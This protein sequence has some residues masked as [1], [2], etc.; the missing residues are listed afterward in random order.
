MKIRTASGKRTNLAALILMLS[1][2]MAAAATA[3]KELTF[4]EVM[5]FRQ[6]RDPVVSAD[7]AWLAYAAQPDRGDGEGFVQSVK[8]ERSF[9]IERGANPV[10]SRDSRWAA[11]TIT[12]RALELEKAGKEKPRQGMALVRLS[13]GEVVLAENVEQFAFS[14]DSA[15]LAYRLFPEEPKE[16]KNEAD[17]G[18]EKKKERG[19][20]LVLRKLASGVEVRIPQTLSFAFDESG[21]FLAY[22]RL[23]PKEADNGLLLRLLKKEGCPEKAAARAPGIRYSS[24]T[25]SEKDGR[26]AFVAAPLDDKDRSGPGSLRLW[27]AETER[28]RTAA[29][30]RS[31]PAGWGI[32]EKNRLTWTKDGRRLFFGIKPMEHFDRERETQDGKPSEEKDLYD[33]EKILAETEVDVWHWNDPLINSHQKKLWARLKDRLFTAVFH[34]DSGKTVPL[35]VTDMPVVEPVE[36]PV[37]ALGMS[38][39][40]YLKERTWDGEYFDLFVVSLADGTRKPVAARI[41]SAYRSRPSLSPEGRYAVYYDRGHWFLYDGRLDKTVNLTSGLGVPFGDEEHDTPDESPGYGLAGWLENDAAVLINDKFDVWI[42]P[43]SGG[44]PSMLTGGAGRREGRIFRV[45]KTDPEFRFFSKK[46]TLLLSMFHER[47]KHHGFYSARI[48]R[49][50][51]TRLLE[52]KKKFVFRAKAENADVVLYT[53]ESFEE[54]PDLWA[55]DMT[56]AAARRLT[57]INPRIREFAWGSAEL[58]EWLSLDGRPLQ[59]V[60]IKPAGYEKGKRYPVLVYFYEI[61][62]HRLYEYNQTV[63]NHRPCFPVYAGRGY[64]VFLPDVRYETGRPGLSALKCVAPGVQK[65]ID[66][67]VADPKALGLHGHSWG[68]YETAFIVTQTDMFACAIA[69]AAVGNMTSAYGGIRWESGMAR[70]FQYEKSQSRIGGSLWESP[71]LYWA[72]SP[73]FLADRIRTPL[74]LMHGDEDGAVPWYQSIELYLAMRRLGKDCIFLQYRGEPHHPRKYANK[75]DY[76][77]RMMEYLDHHLRGLPAPDWMTKG[78]AYDGR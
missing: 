72:N 51:A 16:G 31:V 37:R 2:S 58:V 5:K 77:I 25:W 44:A 53:R 9:R 42:F 8:E 64:C 54:F 41:A 1:C 49:P 3:K 74:L 11:L 73:V 26:L 13:D 20:T 62:S 34:L 69:G 27:E 17:I 52:D 30:D 6:L 56:F 47:E 76:S 75:L 43:T 19:R 61:S 50:G 35:A 28:L 45:L 65:L 29:E 67:G 22:D 57:E 4:A 78:I 71:E 68:G 48:G 40:P 33:P 60:L 7:G 39:V 46:E 21:A 32:P 18:K 70:Q 63:V 10:F 24:L 12:P 38:D 59:G 36:N 14:G 55:T 23:G 15:W 66:S